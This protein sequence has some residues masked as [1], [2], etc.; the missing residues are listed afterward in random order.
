MDVAI[1]Q[2]TAVAII[3]MHKYV[4]GRRLKPI[5]IFGT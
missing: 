3:S 1:F 4:L 5:E 2:I